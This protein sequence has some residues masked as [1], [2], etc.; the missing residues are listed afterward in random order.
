MF[1]CNKR[2]QRQ[3][4]TF[5]IAHRQFTVGIRR[6]SEF[7][8]RLRDHF[9]T[10]TERGKVVNLRAA[11]EHGKRRI[12]IGN[13]NAG[14]RRFIAVYIK[15]VRRRIHTERRICRSDFGSL[16]DFGQKLLRDFKHFLR[17]VATAILQVHRETAGRSQAWNRWRVHGEHIRFRRL[18]AETK[19]FT[20]ERLNALIVAGT[21]IPML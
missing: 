9:I 10:L 21:F 16:I 20:D 11:V 17:T 4:L 7:L 18:E 3:H 1:R 2:T 8:I 19:R 6:H 15:V 14:A 13:V 5:L 12:D